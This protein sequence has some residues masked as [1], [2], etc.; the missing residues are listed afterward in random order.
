ME[1]AD[2][3][4]NTVK[5]RD[6]KSTTGIQKDVELPLPKSIWQMLVESSVPDCV[7]L[8]KTLIETSERLKEEALKAEVLQSI[9]TRMRVLPGLGLVGEAA[10]HR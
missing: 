8:V 10:G 5:H 2:A 7:Q 4:S 6:G 9:A 3:E 1:D